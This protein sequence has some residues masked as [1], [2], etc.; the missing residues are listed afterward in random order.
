MSY[1]K[2][3]L[4]VNERGV[5]LCRAKRTS[6][7]TRA[8]HHRL[9]KPEAGHIAKLS[10]PL[11][12]Y[13]RN[14]VHNS[15]SEETLDIN[16]KPDLFSP[17]LQEGQYERVGEEK[18][19]SVDVRIIAASNR[20]LKK[21]ADAGRFRSDLYYRLNV[22]PV[23]V[24]PLRQRKEDIP[25]LA[26]HYLDLASK[27]LNR[28][29]L[30]STKANVLDL[31]RYDWPGNVRKLQ[32]LIERAVITSRSGRLQ[33]DLPQVQG[34]SEGP[35]P[36]ARAGLESE[37][38]VVTDKEMKSRERQN[39]RAALEKANWK[40]YGSGGAAELLGMKPTTLSSRIRKFGLRKPH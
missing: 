28:L 34:E 13:S 11:A 22:F 2:L 39:V 4:Y 23:E 35:A 32:N 1:C 36:Q 29:E 21:E 10:K 20:N 37:M 19:R 26:A 15:P 17:P 18:T 16:P 7:I 24:T 3:A 31:Q 33:F 14:R 30:R 5:K 9:E 38:E 25:V 6:G 12:S 8:S 40:I 27:R